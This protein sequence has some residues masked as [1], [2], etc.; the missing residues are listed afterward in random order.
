MN[1]MVNGARVGSALNYGMGGVAAIGNFHQ[2]NTNQISVPQFFLE[3]YS[4]GISTFSHPLVAV[5]WTVGYEVFGRQIYAR[6]VF[7]LRS[8]IRP[9]IRQH[10]LGINE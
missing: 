2:L 3:M 4:T 6:N 1:N 5:P 10:V 9:F 7:G 8:R